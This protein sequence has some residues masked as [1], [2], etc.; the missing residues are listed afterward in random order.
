MILLI[1]S[2]PKTKEPPR[3]GVQ[4]KAEFII[5][6]SW[7]NDSDDDIDTFFLAPTGEL[8]F[9]PKRSLGVYNLERDDQGKRTDML[10]DS[11][12]THFLPINREVVSM[13]GYTAG[14][15][16]VSAFFYAK[17]SAGDETVHVR[18]TKLN[19]YRVVYEK[20]YTMTTEGQEVTLC[21]FTLD[22]S[23]NVVS[24]NDVLYP[25]LPATG[26]TT[27]ENAPLTHSSS[28]EGTSP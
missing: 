9:F 23:G 15:Y 16:H 2:I 19:P 20:D 24:T 1:L 26:I 11:T 12:G 18:I 28:A 13:R 3:S 27:S 14:T 25:L 21:N 17:R 4:E 5:E 22:A 8:V 10:T 6:V 7:N